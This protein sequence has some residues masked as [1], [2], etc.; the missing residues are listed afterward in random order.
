MPTMLSPLQP[1]NSIKYNF[2]STAMHKLY[3]TGDGVQG[4]TFAFLYI[5]PWSKT[6]HTGHHHW[7]M[8]R[9]FMTRESH[10][11]VRHPVLENTYTIHLTPVLPFDRKTQAD[12]TSSRK[13]VFKGNGNGETRKGRSKEHLRWGPRK[14]GDPKRHPHRIRGDA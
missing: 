10:S 7:H 2:T 6:Q 9:T 5:W 4:I 3:L 8:K 1:D 13:G 12:D 14:K 11:C